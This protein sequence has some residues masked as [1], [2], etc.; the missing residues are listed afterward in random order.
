MEIGK[1]HARFADLTEHLRE[2]V[3]AN[4]H[5]WAEFRCNDGS[6]SVWVQQ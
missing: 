4:E 3:V 2:P 5:G 1:P 6:V